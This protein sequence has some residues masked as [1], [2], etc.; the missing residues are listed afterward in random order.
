MIKVGKDGKGYIVKKAPKTKKNQLKPA[1][2]C[3][4][5][6]CKGHGVRRER[7]NIDISIPCPKCH[8]EGEIEWLDNFKKEIHKIPHEILQRFFE[9]NMSRFIKAMKSE[10]EKEGIEID[11]E[12]IN[13]MTDLTKNDF[14]KRWEKLNNV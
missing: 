3:E 7:I 4:C 1:D 9:N 8:G 11:V 10:A 13:K 12:I 2:Y 5:S 6:S 14:E